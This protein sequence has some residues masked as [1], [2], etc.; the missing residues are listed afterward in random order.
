MMPTTVSASRISDLS[1]EELEAIYKIKYFRF[2]DPGWGPRT[3]RAFKY[4][5]PDDYY[6]AMVA[7][8]ISPGCSW[9]DVGCGRDIFPSNPDLA[10]NLSGRAGYVFGIDPDDNIREN[11]YLTEGFQGVVEDCRTDRRFDVITLRM[12]A[13]HIVDPARVVAKLAELLAAGGRLVLYT[14]YKWSPMAV[15]AT[16]VPFRLHNPLKRLIW[17]SEPRD[18][19]PTAYK[20]N[21][22]A[23]LR[24][25]MLERGLVEE[26]FAM[27]DDCSISNRYRVL[28]WGELALCRSLNAIGLNHPERCILAVYR[29]RLT[30]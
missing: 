22:R 5:L 10:R 14:P 8:L 18:T 13:E 29:K 9:A 30:E 17:N 21:T 6:E 2:G 16:V 15:V 20:L 26:Y 27:L 23:D 24:R 28:N 1:Q 3:R 25:H 19:F 4:F 12:V 11:R 7:R